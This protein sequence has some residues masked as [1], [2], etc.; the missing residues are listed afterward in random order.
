M[1]KIRSNVQNDIFFIRNDARK[2]VC[3]MDW[4]GRM[5]LISYVF[6]VFCLR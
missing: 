3:R 2:E 6:M 5:L 1:E 4:L